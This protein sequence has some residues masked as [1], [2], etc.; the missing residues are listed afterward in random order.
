MEK[1]KLVE[2]MKNE[3][4]NWR[5]R[6]DELRVQ[7]RLGQAEM[8]QVVQP[9][10]EKIEQELRKVEEQAKQLQSASDNALDDIKRGV[11][12]ALKAIQES[13]GK[14]SSQFKK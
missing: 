14:A 11:D 3:M 9:E 6:L 13:F 4:Q 8:R 12:T 2:M 10:I 7:A 1:E 5:T